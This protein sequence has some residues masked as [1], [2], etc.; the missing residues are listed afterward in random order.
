MHEARFF[1]KKPK[2]KHFDVIVVGA[3]IGGLMVAKQLI[4]IDKQIGIFEEN[5]SPGGRLYSINSLDLGAGRFCFDNHLILRQLANEFHLSLESFDYELYYGKDHEE[6]LEKQK[7]RVKNLY[8][9]NNLF[10]GSFIEEIRK[11]LGDH[12]AEALCTYAGYDTLKDPSLPFSVG[13]SVALNHPESLS[14]VGKRWVK[15]QGGFQTLSS[16][17]FECLKLSRCHFYYEHKLLKIIK[18]GSGYELSFKQGNHLLKVQ[19]DKA[20][21]AIPLSSLGQFDLDGVSF[22]KQIRDVPLF[23][24]FLKYPVSWWKTKQMEGKCLITPFPMRKLYFS[25]TEPLIW[26]YA[27]GISANLWRKRVAQKD[28]IHRLKEELAAITHIKEIPDPSHCYYKYWDVGVSFWHHSYQFHTPCN[29]LE[30][31]P[32]LFICSDLF[33]SFPGWVEGSLISASSIAKTITTK[34]GASNAA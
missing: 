18:S 3:G 13:C 26:Y 16:K 23:K 34:H 21:L 7:N 27:D 14:N 11:L 1:Q 12:E 4:N 17:L 6:K 5:Q 19:C 15:F 25:K 8:N 20:I 10:Q 32:D 24:C 33:T 30:I 9:L 29:H 2:F 28:W 22:L 31:A